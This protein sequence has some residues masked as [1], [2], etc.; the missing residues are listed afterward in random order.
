LANE[1]HRL[2]LTSSDYVRLAA[3][4]FVLVNA[5]EGRGGELLRSRLRSS[6]VMLRDAVA[7]AVPVGND[8][9]AVAVAVDV[10]VAVPVIN[11]PLEQTL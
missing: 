3:E 2:S 9:D 4:N 6:V 5:C 1:S 10:A 7:V 8:R 11:D